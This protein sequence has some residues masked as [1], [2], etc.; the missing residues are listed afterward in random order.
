MG[1]IFVGMVSAFVLLIAKLPADLG[2]VDA[3]ALA[4]GF[5]K[6]KAVNFSIDLQERYTFWSGLLGGLFL[7]LSYF[8]ADQSQVQRYLAGARCAIAASLDVQCGGIRCSSHPL[9]GVF[10][11]SYQFIRRRYSSTPW[12]QQ[13][14]GRDDLPDSTGICRA[15]RHA[16]A[17]LADR[18]PRGRRPKPGSPMPRVRLRHCGSGGP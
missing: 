13:K 6:L 8:G 16:R 4:G 2:V 14:P 9:P 11:P 7:A 1:I 3:L 10:L 17:G 15:Q 12:Q 5:D 18:A